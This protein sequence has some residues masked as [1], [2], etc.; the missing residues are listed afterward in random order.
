MPGRRSPI[1]VRDMRD[2][3][4]SSYGL[5]L[6]CA[7]AGL[8]TLVLTRGRALAVVV[9]VVALV[10]IGGQIMASLRDR[11]DPPG[12]P[13]RN[14]TPDE[15][16]AAAGSTIAPREAASPVVVIEPATA[17]EVSESLE[18]KLATL[19]RLRDGGRLTDAEYEA[20]RAQLIADF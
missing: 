18:A 2:A 10:V 14:V 8:A 19:D 11:R 9:I 6:I 5:L 1:I 3:W 17:G 15:P 13:P 20:K 12:R 7:G 4:R 16:S